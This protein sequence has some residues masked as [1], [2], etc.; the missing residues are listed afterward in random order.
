MRYY[1]VWEPKE[2]SFDV[3]GLV[4]CALLGSFL[5]VGLALMLF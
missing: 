3:M 1:Q 2:K 5:G 4:N